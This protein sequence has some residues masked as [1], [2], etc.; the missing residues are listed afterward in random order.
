MALSED[1]SQPIVTYLAFR[2][3]GP[4]I[5]EELQAKIDNFTYPRGWLA[6]DVIAKPQYAGEQWCWESSLPETCPRIL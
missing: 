6:G 1:E 3:T 2:K 5:Y 4:R